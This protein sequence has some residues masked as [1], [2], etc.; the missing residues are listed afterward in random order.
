MNEE[1]M[2]MKFEKY[3][4]TEEELIMK[5]IFEILGEDLGSIPLYDDNSIGTGGLSRSD[6]VL[7]D[8][9]GDCELSPSDSIGE[10]QKALS[11][12]GLKQLEFADK[13][14]EEQIQ[15]RIQDIEEELGV[16]LDYNWDYDEF[17]R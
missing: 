12:C 1:D 2:Y 15:Q 3:T 5:S 9:M 7:Y 8:F 6:E 11:E 17:K 4:F 10:L 14:V 13:V 16:K